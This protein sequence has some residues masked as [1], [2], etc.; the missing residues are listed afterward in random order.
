MAP[1]SLPDRIVIDIPDPSLVVLVGAAGAGKTTFA[2]RHFA[3]DEVLSSDAFRGLVAGD[4]ADQAATRPAFAALHRALAARMF[5]R[6]LTV[7]DA[8][9]VQAHA[10]R[11]LLARATRAG[12][13]AIAIVLDL[14]RDVVLARNASR[15]GGALVPEPAVIAQL[16]ALLAASQDDQPPWQGFLAVVRL[17]TPEAVDAVVVRRLVTR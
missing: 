11:S 3:P 16:D 15:T 2:A 7:V 17:R 4:P 10:R 13:P 8:T 1:P 6:R 12:I 14:P 5:G 9:N